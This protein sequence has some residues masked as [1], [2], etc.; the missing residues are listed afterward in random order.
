MKRLAL[1]V[2]LVAGV[3]LAGD[4]YK[5]SVASSGS[6]ACSGTL[7]PKFQYAVQCDAAAYV[8][9]G[10]G[11]SAAATTSGVKVAADELYDVVVPHD[12]NKICALRVAGSGTATCKIFRVVPQ[13]LKGL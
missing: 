1:A 5:E 7:S 12:H 13:Q 3:A 10:S 11:S 4:V 9:T 6:S 8:E 2:V